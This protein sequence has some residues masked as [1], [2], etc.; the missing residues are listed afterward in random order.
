MLD[1]NSPMPIGEHQGKPMANVPDSDLI[2]IWEKYSAM[3]GKSITSGALFNVLEYIKDFGPE[4]L[5]R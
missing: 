5:K 3:L 1:D 4:N 2:R